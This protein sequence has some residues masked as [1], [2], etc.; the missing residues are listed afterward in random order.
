MRKAFTIVELLVVI[1]LIVILVGILLPSVQY[2]REA[3]RQARCINHQKQLALA[4]LTH[5]NTKGSLPGWRE[6]TTVRP[7]Q[8]GI[9]PPTGYRPDGDEITA[10]TS[11]VFAILP[12]IERTDIF[13]A[14]KSGQR[15]V[16]DENNP[17]TWMPSIDILHCPSYG[18]DHLNL[19]LSENAKHRAMNYVING[20]PA[21]DFT[22]QDR[23]VTVDINI[24]NGPF[25]DKAGIFAAGDGGNFRYSRDH[26]LRPSSENSQYRHTVARLA[27]ISKMDGTAYTLLTSENAQRGFWISEDIV[28]F[29][30]NRDGSRSRSIGGADWFL[31][32]L[33]VR[34]WA[35]QLT[36]FDD[37]IEGS[38]AFCC[39]RHYVEPAAAS[40]VDPNNANYLDIWQICYP[41]AGFLGNNPKQ[42]F[43]AVQQDPEPTSSY[44]SPTGGERTPCYIGM[45][46]RKEFSGS[47][48]WYQSARPA[49]HHAGIVVAS[50]CDGT[51]RKLNT[52]INEVVFVQLMAA[53]DAQS[54]AGWRFPPGNEKN[55]LEGKLFDAQVLK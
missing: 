42:G 27:D 37:T 45:F 53:G 5:E 7:P 51:V 25:L 38:V 26:R 11:W 52:D 55:F 24:A 40:S 23:F 16:V 21:D 18:G 1:S 31:L 39:P 44:V 17:N 14:V 15:P 30:N 43:V 29:Y 8:A 4:L 46:P 35:L 6:F 34:R 28:H 48:S 41:R 33:P 50:F 9:T 12:Q 36:G 54:D 3:A 22:D 13:D 47:W 32:N 49:S 20:G 19:T 2:A 10:Q